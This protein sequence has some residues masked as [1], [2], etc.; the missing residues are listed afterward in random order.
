MKK[1]KLLLLTGALFNTVNFFGSSNK[2]LLTIEIPNASQYQESLND[3]QNKLQL[4]ENEDLNYI[5]LDDQG[6]WQD[7]AILNSPPLD[8]ENEI[9]LY[10]LTRCRAKSEPIVIHHTSQ[11]NFDEKK[12]TQ[13]ARY[14]SR[15]EQDTIAHYMQYQS[16][17]HRDMTTSNTRDNANVLI[18]D[19]INSDE[20][21]EQDDS[22]DGCQFDIRL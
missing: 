19:T 1:Y 11:D 17:A 4:D 2:K 10:S 13:S 9:N 22:D 7:Q 12:L 16:P 8:D 3:Q 15:S 5:F 18:D 20:N 21:D 14:A 6:N